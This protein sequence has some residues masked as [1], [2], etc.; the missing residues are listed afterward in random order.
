MQPHKLQPDFV[1]LSIF[2][3]DAR[4][5]RGVGVVGDVSVFGGQIH[6]DPQ[7]PSPMT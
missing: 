6:R 7:A 4:L 3:G 2:G 5:D 1:T